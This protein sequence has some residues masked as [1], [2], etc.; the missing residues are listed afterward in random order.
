MEQHNQRLLFT[1]PS[2]YYSPRTPE[3]LWLMQNNSNKRIQSA[4]SYGEKRRPSEDRKMKIEN[5]G[6]CIAKPRFI[7]GTCAARN[8]ERS[9]LNQ[10]I[11]LPTW[12]RQTLRAVVVVSLP[13]SGLVEKP[14]S[15]VACKTRMWCLYLMGGFKLTFFLSSTKSVG[16][17]A[18][19]EVIYC[20]PVAATLSGLVTYKAQMNENLWSC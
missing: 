12:L 5:P 2:L 17:L 9:P 13:A 7:V 14:Q 10:T 15:T 8:P 18:G 20:S 1:C 11:P 16:D 4:T 19:N 6:V 3:R